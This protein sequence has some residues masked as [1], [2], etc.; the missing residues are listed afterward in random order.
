MSVVFIIVYPARAAC[1]GVYVIGAGVH[2]YV[3]VFMWTKNFFFESYVSDRL[4]F[5]NIHGKTS[6]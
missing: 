6:R 4:T 2:M 1:A 5:S 3:Y